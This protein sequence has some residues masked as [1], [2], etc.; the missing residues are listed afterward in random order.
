MAL[1][2]TLA[3]VLGG[4]DQETVWKACIGDLTST[5][6]IQKFGKRHLCQVEAL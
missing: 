6:G 2:A 4:A 5:R 1:A 3:S